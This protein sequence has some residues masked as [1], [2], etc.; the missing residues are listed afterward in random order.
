MLIPRAPTKNRASRSSVNADPAACS[1]TGSDADCNVVLID[2]SEAVRESTRLLLKTV[3]LKLTAFASPLRYLE[4]MPQASCVL[5]DVRMPEMSGMEVYRR[6]RESGCETPTIFITGHGRVAMA[7]DAMRD[8]AFDFLEKPIDDQRLIDTVFSAIARD[9]DRRRDAGSREAVASKLARLTQRER[10]IA[11]MIAEGL[12]S[13]EVAEKLTL[14]VR[15][16]EGYRSRI[17]AKLEANSLAHLIRIV[18]ET[19]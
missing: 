19:K 12:S 18:H 17:L 2:D 8:G 4:E 11:E 7:V 5:L 16:V 3:G 9:T 1:S 13:R 10:T 15:T 6:M 14:S